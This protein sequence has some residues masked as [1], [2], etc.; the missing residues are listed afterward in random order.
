M[1]KIIVLLAVITFSA[2]SYAKEENPLAN[3]SSNPGL[4]GIFHKWGFIGDSLSS[5]E[6]EYKKPD[7]SNGYYDAYPYSWGQR[8]C[9]LMGTKGD[10][11]SKGG[12]TAYGWISHFWDKPDN[13]NGN[14]CAKDDP[15][16]AYIIAL[17]VN[18]VRMK[19]K[20]G[21]EFYQL[22]SFDTDVNPGD[23][24]LNAQTF[25]GC[26]A[27]IIQRVRSIEPRCRIFLV[28][29][30]RVNGGEEKV[31]YNKAIRHMADIFDNIYILD[32]EKYVPD[33]YVQG[34]EWRKKYYL[35][36]H[37]SPAGYEY[38]AWMFL[39]YIDWIIRNDMDAF[40]DVGFIGTD[41]AL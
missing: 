30:P 38:T 36:G 23:Y 28:T 39:T 12:E 10:N 16:Q 20:P 34:S 4:C 8:M 27:G 41:L 3:V 18:D 2:A 24:S 7:G 6:F 17:G 1:K 14:I 19:T 37:L 32:L 26:Y 22:G 21:K 13:K 25:I 35:R 15:K 29:M 11:Y 31:E 5:G 33:Q 9:A 40:K